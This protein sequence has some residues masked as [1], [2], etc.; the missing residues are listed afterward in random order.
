MSSDKASRPVPTPAAVKRLTREY[1]KLLADPDPLMS[2]HWDIENDDILVWHFV[3]K[4]AEGTPYENGWYL[5]KFVLS[6]QHPFRPPAIYMIT[7]NARLKTDM[8][9]CTTFSDYHPE[10]WGAGW[11]IKSMVI[12]LQSFLADSDPTYGSINA[13]DEERRRLAR[14]SIAWNRRHPA[15]RAYFGDVDAR[16]AAEEAAKAAG[17]AA[18][19]AGDAPKAEAKPKAEPGSA[20]APIDLDDEDHAKPA[21]EDEAPAKRHKPNATAKADATK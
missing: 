6:P 19:A 7:P 20:V 11:P 12:G 3:F 14:E 21:A 10:Q 17:E 5:G 13:S 1:Q 8:R 18:K 4:G 9:L 16:I 2:A 15:Y